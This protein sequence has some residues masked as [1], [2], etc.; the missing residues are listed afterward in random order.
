MQ[1]IEM[2]L[3]IYILIKFA[4]TILKLLNY[5]NILIEYLNTTKNEVSDLIRN[6]LTSTIL[7]LNL[8]LLIQ[9]RLT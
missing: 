4:H 6:T 5:G 2:T 3:K 1:K 7:N 8:K 9:L